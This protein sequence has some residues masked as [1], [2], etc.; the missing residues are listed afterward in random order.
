M[1]GMRQ[2]VR[3]H[4]YRIHD[5]GREQMCVASETRCH[6]IGRRCNTGGRTGVWKRIPVFGSP[7]L[8]S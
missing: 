3:A 8:E 1:L 6:S 4:C 7:G 2:P 5:S